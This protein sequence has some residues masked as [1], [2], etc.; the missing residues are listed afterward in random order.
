MKKLASLL[1]DLCPPM[2]YMYKS[3][4]QTLSFEFHFVKRVRVLIIYRAAPARLHCAERTNEVGLDPEHSQSP[5]TRINQNQIFYYTRCNTPKRVTS[6]RGPSPRHC[7][8]ATQLLSKKCRSSGEPL[9]TLSDLT[10]PR[11]EPQTSR[12][13]DERVTARPTGRYNSNS[14]T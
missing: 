2:V 11:F 8:R 1:T 13:R 7:A 5:T 4:S 6:W 10:G 3:V 9:A 14:R 12:F